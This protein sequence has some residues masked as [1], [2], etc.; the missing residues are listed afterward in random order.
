MYVYIKYIRGYVH[1]MPP[2]TLWAT[3]QTGPVSVIMHPFTIH[4]LHY[5]YSDGFSVEMLLMPLFYLSISLGIHSICRNINVCLHVEVNGT[6][7]SQYRETHQSNRS[8]LLAVH[9]RQETEQHTFCILADCCMYVLG[10]K[11]RMHILYCN[12]C[13]CVCGGR[14]CCN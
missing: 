2:N 14:N 8:T 4:V 3:K 7:Y 5:Y 6:F 1:P 10:I 13:V 12:M 11:H 9:L